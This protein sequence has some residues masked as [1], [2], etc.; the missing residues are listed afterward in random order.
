MK[1]MNKDENRIDD[2]L[3]PFMESEETKI[4]K[5]Y[6][7]H[8]GAVKAVFL[9]LALLVLSPLVVF[10]WCHDAGKDWSDTVK[11]VIETAAVL[12][13]VVAVFKWITERQDRAT[14]I[15]L[16]LNEEF[17]KVIKG[18]QLIDDNNKYKTDAAPSLKR[19]VAEKWV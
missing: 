5:W 13:G 4:G 16:M 6:R 9:C 11:N 8:T 7:K 3:A 19:A 10:W 14:D 1:H 18:K 15:L 17:K 12:C 2:I